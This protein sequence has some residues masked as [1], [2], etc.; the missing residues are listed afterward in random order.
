MCGVVGCLFGSTTDVALGRH[1]TDMHPGVKRFKCSQCSF[2]SIRKGSLTRHAKVHSDKKEFQCRECSSKFKR[3]EHLTQH[4]KIHSDKK[5]FQCHECS[6]KCKRKFL[7]TQHAQVHSDKKEFQCRECSSKF[8][9][10]EHLTQHEKIH[11][12]KKEFQCHECSFKSKRKESLTRHIKTKHDVPAAIKILLRRHPTIHDV[13]E[14]LELYPEETEELLRWYFSNLDRANEYGRDISSKKWALND[15]WRDATQ[16]FGSHQ[17]LV[18]YVVLGAERTAAVAKEFLETGKH[19]VYIFQ[20][21]ESHIAGGGLGDPGLPGFEFKEK[22]LGLK[23]PECGDVPCEDA[24]EALRTLMIGVNRP[25]N[26]YCDGNG[27]SLDKDLIREHARVFITMRHS[28][29]EVVACV[30]SGG[31]KLVRQESNRN[32]WVREMNRLDHVLICGGKYQPSHSVGVLVVPMH[33]GDVQ[34]HRTTRS[35]GGRA[36]FRNPA[37]IEDHLNRVVTHMESMAPLVVPQMS[38]EDLSVKLSVRYE[39]HNKAEN[40]PDGQPGCVF[41]IHKS[42]CIVQEGRL[43]HTLSQRTS[44]DGDGMRVDGRGGRR[45]STKVFPNTQAATTY[46]H[47]VVPVEMKRK[48]YKLL[49]P[50]VVDYN[51]KAPSSQ[52][53]SLVYQETTPVLKPVSP[54]KM[55]VSFILLPPIISSESLSRRPSKK[56]KIKKFVDKVLSSQIQD[57]EGDESDFMKSLLSYDQSDVS[58][59]PVREDKKS[60]Q[61]IVPMELEEETS[62]VPLVLSNVSLIFEGQADRDSRM[63][64]VLMS[65]YL[66]RADRKK[67]SK[68]KHGQAFLVT[69]PSKEGGGHFDSLTLDDKENLC[70]TLNFR[71]NF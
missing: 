44:D 52:P 57:D 61:D 19:Y 13:R 2:K 47:D 16:Q 51:P 54:R 30:E 26:Q 4:E 17:A 71:V 21:G 65:T 32:L 70:V 45:T 67:E 18:D 50:L 62:Q 28:S 64:A 38:P 69:P 29:K 60:G 66:R 41:G 24:N 10:K 33:M 53:F 25:D 1:Y 36:G 12:D 15:I 34:V 48:K 20:A 35:Y 40:I 37:L 6:F 31:I 56:P 8:K 9:R 59:E 23:A 58:I 55:K 7:L 43:V 5:E 3:K 11:S 14:I 27:N 42:K 39:S 22:R 68:R 46:V 63:E 49:D